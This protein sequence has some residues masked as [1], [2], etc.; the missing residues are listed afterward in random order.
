MVFPSRL[1]LDFC[2]FEIWILGDFHT[3]EICLNLVRYQKEKT[4]SNKNGKQMEKVSLL[5]FLYIHLTLE[6]KWNSC[7]SWECAENWAQISVAFRE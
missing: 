4:N 7:E 3:N 1:L 2:Q 6:F 5:P